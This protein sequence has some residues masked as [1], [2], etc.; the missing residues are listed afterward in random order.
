M[1]VA[2]GLLHSIPGLHTLDV[3]IIR[4]PLGE[5][6]LMVENHWVKFRFPDISPV[7]QNV[8][9]KETRD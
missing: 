7:P 8:P 4:C 5:K 6:Q 9:G 1:I 2:F 3:V